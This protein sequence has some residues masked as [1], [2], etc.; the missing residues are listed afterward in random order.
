MANLAKSVSGRCG[1]YKHQASPAWGLIFA[2]GNK[3]EDLDGPVASLNLRG[4]HWLTGLD[5]RS[6]PIH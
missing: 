6:C 1:N 5:P 2:E 4:Y 3:G